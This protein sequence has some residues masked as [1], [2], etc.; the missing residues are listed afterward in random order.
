MRTLKNEIYGQLARN[1]GLLPEDMAEAIL[2]GNTPP[3]EDLVL[4]L[5]IAA[6]DGYAV[7][8]GHPQSSKQD[9]P[10]PRQVPAV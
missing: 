3:T 8:T 4:H 7:L 10:C 5:V 6:W 1:T 2:A 9:H